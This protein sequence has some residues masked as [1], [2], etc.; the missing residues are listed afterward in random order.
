MAALSISQL[1]PLLDSH[2]VSPDVSLD[3]SS[4]L[5][6]APKASTMRAGSKALSHLLLNLTWFII[7]NFPLNI[8]SLL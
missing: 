4:E 1:V 2:D 7:F 3:C 8:G 6:Q 5:E